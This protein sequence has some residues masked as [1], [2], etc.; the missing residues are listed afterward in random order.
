M[1]NRTPLMLTELII[2]L[3]VFLLAVALGFSAFAKADSISK[4]SEARDR[5]VV[6]AKNVAEQLEATN[7]DIDAA[8]AAFAA[9][10]KEKGVELHIEKR[11]NENK[12]LG[13]AD[14]NVF[15]DNKPVF[16]LEAAWQEVGT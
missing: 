8:I 9:Q 1:K 15:F 2:M 11:I 16:S 4:E 7:G 12:Y 13:I 14:I 5:A 3:F 10:A 6:L